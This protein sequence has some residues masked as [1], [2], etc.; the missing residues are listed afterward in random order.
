MDLLAN[1]PD[2]RQRF[3]EIYLAVA[4]WMGQRH[5]GFT[6]PRAADPHMILHDRVATREAMLVPEPLENPLG[7]VPLLHRRIAIRLQDR[8]DHRQQRPQFRLLGRPCAR[9]PGRQ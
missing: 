4:W 9:V 2:H 8:V 5:E 1:A 7:R 6:P 3:T